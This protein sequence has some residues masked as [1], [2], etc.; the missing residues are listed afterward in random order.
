M[1]KLSKYFF[2]SPEFIFNAEP[3]MRAMGIFTLLSIQTAWKKQLKLLD[4]VV[5]DLL[6]END[7]E[8][9]QYKRYFGNS[10]TH[11]KKQRIAQTLLLL[12]SLFNEVCLFFHS[13]I[14]GVTNCRNVGIVG[15]IRIKMANCSNAGIKMAKCTNLGIKMTLER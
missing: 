14:L 8:T 10:L 5:T 3:K 4:P 2:C 7:L 12:Q 6:N 15:I 11:R 9:A 13:S 1:S